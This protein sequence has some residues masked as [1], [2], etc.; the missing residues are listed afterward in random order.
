MK[1]KKNFFIIL[2]TSL[3][4][5]SCSNAVEGFKLKKK[6]SAGEEFLIEKKDPLILPPEFSKLP[7][8]NNQVNDKQEEEINLETVF[9]N[10]NSENKEKDNNENNSDSGIKKSILKKIQK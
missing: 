5:F 7:K 10:D 1:I 3:L 4:L 6:S 8:P 9:K 2:L